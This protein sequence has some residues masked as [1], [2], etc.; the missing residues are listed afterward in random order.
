M[1]VGLFLACAVNSLYLQFCISEE[2]D[3]I[4]VTALFPMFCWLYGAL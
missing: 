3:V 1:Q 2:F 4:L